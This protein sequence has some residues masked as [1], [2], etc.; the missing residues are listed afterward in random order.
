MNTLYSTAAQ[1][2]NKIYEYAASGLPVIYFQNEHY[3]R[4][5]GTFKWAFPTNLTEQSLSE[6]I[7]EIQSDYGKVSE[8]AL[9]DFQNKLYFGIGFRP[10]LSVLFQKVSVS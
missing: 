5:L 1:A 2:S 6:V 3:S 8:H 9:D 4:Y 10:V 7:M